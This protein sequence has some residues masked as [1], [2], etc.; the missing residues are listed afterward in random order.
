MPRDGERR[1][2]ETEMAQGARTWVDIPRPAEQSGKTAETLPPVPVD[3]FRA[4]V[5]PNNVRD[6]RQ[7]GGYPRLLQLSAALPDISYIR[8]SKIERGEVFP[9]PDELRR[10]AATLGIAPH[11]LLLDVAAPDF[12]I[13]RWAAPFFDPDS[14]DMTEERF[15]VLLGAA[16]RARRAQDGALTIAA[17]ERDF[18]LP[19]VNLSRIENAAKTFSRWNMSVQRA[20]YTLFDVPDE[21]ALR[22]LVEERY[23]AGLLNGWLHAV[24]DPATR[25]ARAGEKTRELATALAGETPP[26]P[27]THI[28]T[29]MGAP[30][31]AM[32]PAPDAAPRTLPILGGTMADGVIAATPTGGT[33][34]AP[35]NAGP[36][37]FAL[38]IARAT[39]GPGLPAGSIAIADPDRAPVP[40]G[41]VAVRDGAGWRLLFTTPDRE[42]RMMGHSLHPEH[43]EMI[44]DRPPGEIAGLVNAFFPV[45]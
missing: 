22:H 12:D 7:H 1:A 38:K 18:G 20:L 8:L 2:R 16:M 45:A 24:S 19:P 29:H 41:I 3:P 36:R 26:A 14:L 39:L 13:A 28:G 31:P 33:I 9:R 37:A 35:V 5:F 11:A 27:N 30:T 17:L 40:G 15:A 32:S 43:S 42:G 44:D 21:A 10:I 6:R 34:A 23:R 25:L 4:I